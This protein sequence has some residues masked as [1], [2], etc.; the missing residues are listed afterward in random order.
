MSMIELRLSQVNPPAPEP[1]R[2]LY[3]DIVNLPNPA[4]LGITAHYFNHDSVTL[5]FQITGAGAGYTFGTVN[6]GSLAAGTDAFQDIDSFGSRALP[7]PSQLTNGEMDEYVTLT[8]N[9]YT[10]AGYSNLKWTFTRTVDIHWIN[11]ADPSFTLDALNNFDDGTFDGWAAGNNGDPYT[12]FSAALAT[13][14]V[15]SPPYSLELTAETPAG[16]SVTSNPV[17]WAYKQFTT[18]NATKAF[19]IIDMRNDIS[20]IAVLQNVQVLIGSTVYVE[21][22]NTSGIIQTKWIRMVIPLP[23]NTTF[24]IYIQASGTSTGNTDR[25]WHS[26][27]DDLKI[28]HK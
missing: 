3:R 28:I 5:Y 16:S 19:A 14:Y 15:L 12:I 25:L 11:S 8:L 27:L 20:G 4:L 21:V 10:D 18:P 2:T 9:A 23:M 22:V 13:N 1:S 24:T 26:W 17:Y 7:T 6:L